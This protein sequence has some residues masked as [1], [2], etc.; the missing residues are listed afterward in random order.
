M[1]VTCFTNVTVTG[2][3]ST[4]ISS[5]FKNSTGWVTCEKRENKLTD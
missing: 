5:V 3:T 1:T 4:C 2:L